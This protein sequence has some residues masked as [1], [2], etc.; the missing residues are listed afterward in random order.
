MLHYSN[1]ARR[2]QNHDLDLGEMLEEHPI[3]IRI[4]HDSS[5]AWQS[6]GVC[7]VWNP[8]TLTWNQVSSIL[9]N[10]VHDAY[11][12]ADELRARAAAVLLEV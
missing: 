8:T 10:E 1:E 7:E 4:H 12:A 3:R 11:E 2:G 6:S 9:A 5:Y